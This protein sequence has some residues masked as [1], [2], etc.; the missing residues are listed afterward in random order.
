M[1]ECSYRKISLWFWL[2]NLLFTVYYSNTS[3]NRNCAM[4]FSF[5]MRIL[6][7]KSNNAE[8]AILICIFSNP[9]QGF[10]DLRIQMYLF[11]NNISLVGAV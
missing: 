7:S 9:P 11:S 5:E 6:T 10:K 1:C 3:Y 8:Y 2:S 4:L